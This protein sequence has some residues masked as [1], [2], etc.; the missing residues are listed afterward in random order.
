MKQVKMFYQERCPFCKWAFKYIDELKKEHPEFADIKIEKIDEI[1]EPEVADQYD[2]YYVPTFYV[3][4]QK[5]HE[6][7]IYKPEM[8]KLL[9]QIIS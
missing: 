5:V 8:E 9:R 6:G 7:A 3:D 2:Y 1:K 4:G